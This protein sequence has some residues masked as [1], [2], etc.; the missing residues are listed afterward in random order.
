M[1]VL[2]PQQTAVAI[3]GLVVLLIFLHLVGVFSALTKVV[4]SLLFRTAEPIH[5]LSANLVQN[6]EVKRKCTADT[7][8]Q[9]EQLLLENSKLRTLTAEN[10]ALKGALNFQEKE[11]SRIVLARVVA[12]SPNATNRGLIIDRG[13]ADGLKPGQPVVV[14][15]GII[16]GKIKSVKSNSAIVLLLLDSASKLAV[17]IQGGTDTTLGLLEG[18]RGLSMTISLIPQDERISAGDVVITAGIE[19][20]IKRGLVIGTV[21]QIHKDSQKP[22][23]T[24]LVEPFGQAEHPVFVQVLIDNNS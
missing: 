5:Q 21:E 11:T 6:D 13:A 10:A 16:I 23:Q 24:A 8:T 19:P 18:D 14:N 7:I 22:F 15:D 4:T 20:G 3:A 2:N 12:E 1:K 17:S 9:F